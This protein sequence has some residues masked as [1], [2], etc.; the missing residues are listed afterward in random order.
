MTRKQKG[1]LLILGMLNLIVIL[2]VGSII[3]H[4][5][6]QTISAPPPPLVMVTPTACEQQLLAAFPATM[7]P[8]STWTQQ[9][10]MV[11]LALAESPGPENAQ[12]LWAVLDTLAAIFQEDCPVPETVVIAVSVGSEIQHR[13]LVQL[14]GTDIAAWLAGDLSEDALAAQSRY[15]HI[16]EVAP[17]EP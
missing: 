16:I 6:W 11:Q 17:G 1:V 14:S 5:A 10:L 7:H 15:R 4:D 12:H 9:Q 2:G 8:A 3:L 13:H